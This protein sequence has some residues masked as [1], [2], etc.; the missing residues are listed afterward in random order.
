MFFF[1][2]LLTTGGR[3]WVRRPS[4][5]ALEQQ[6]AVKTNKFILMTSRFSSREAARRYGTG[7]HALVID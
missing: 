7:I 1:I 4:L 2:L 6:N 3:L 5:L